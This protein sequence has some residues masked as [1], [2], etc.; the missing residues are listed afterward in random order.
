[1]V[2]VAAAYGE[3]AV[4]FGGL[5]RYGRPAGIAALILI[6]CFLSLYPMVMLLYGSLHSTPPGMEGVFNLD[7]TNVL[8]ISPFSTMG[9]PV[10]LIKEFGDRQ[11]FETAVREMQTALYEV[12]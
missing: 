6:L 11:G 4:S 9:T 10:Q 3:R 5:W 2:T 12:A 7:D 8:R 1:M